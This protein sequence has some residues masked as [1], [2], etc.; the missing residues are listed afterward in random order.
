RAARGSAKGAWTSSPWGRPLLRHRP[1]RPAPAKGRRADE[2]IPFS[3]LA[4]RSV[5]VIFTFNSDARSRLSRSTSSGASAGRA[6]DVTAVVRVVIPAGGGL[7]SAVDVEDLA[8]DV[9]REVGGEEDGDA[10]EVLKRSEA[11]ERDVQARSLELL[12]V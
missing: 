1:G 3:E 2:S 10:G 11:A 5:K 12:V 6:V 9:A 8:G 7:G 4:A